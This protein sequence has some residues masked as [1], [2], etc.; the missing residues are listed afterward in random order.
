MTC[1]ASK[2]TTN[3]E[4]CPTGKLE[5]VDAAPNPG[6]KAQKEDVKPTTKG[7]ELGMTGGNDESAA[8]GGGSAVAA[9]APPRPDTE[10]TVEVAVLPPTPDDKIINGSAVVAVSLPFACI[11][12]P[13]HARAYTLLCFGQPL[14]VLL[15]MLCLPTA[16]LV[17][18]KP[19]HLVE[20]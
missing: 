12:P 19:T 14:Y 5:N 11:F 8:K 9:A 2:P 18:M 1:D 3:E 17:L 20:F 16:F 6:V 13:Y 15:E 4:L 10:P 7:G